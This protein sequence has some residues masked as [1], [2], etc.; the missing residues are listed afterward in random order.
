MAAQVGAPHVGA[1]SVTGHC[2]NPCS[3]AWHTAKAT[4]WSRGDAGHCMGKLGRDPCVPE[5]PKALNCEHCPGWSRRPS[6][7]QELA[8][9]QP[10]RAA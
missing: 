9:A 3:S 1:V 5:E 10:A 4:E 8:H 2:C 6:L 7:A